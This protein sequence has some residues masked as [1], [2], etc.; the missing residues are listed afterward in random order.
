MSGLAAARKHPDQGYLRIETSLYGHKSDVQP[1]AVLLTPISAGYDGRRSSIASSSWSHPSTVTSIRSSQ[2]PATPPPHGLPMDMPFVCSDSFEDGPRGHEIEAAKKSMLSDPGT[3][4]NSPAAHGHFDVQDYWAYAPVPTQT[5]A[6][7]IPFV[8]MDSMMPASGDF[9][10]ALGVSLVHPPTDV[11]SHDVEQER[12]YPRQWSPQNYE[13]DVYENVTSQSYTVE[14][15]VSS[16]TLSDWSTTIKSWSPSD[17][18]V[19]SCIVPTDMNIDNQNPSY[20]MPIRDNRDT[21]SS[22]CSRLYVRT[23]GSFL[24]IQDQDDQGTCEQP[25]LR[26]SHDRSQRRRSMKRDSKRERKSETRSRRKLRDELP[27]AYVSMGDGFIPLHGKPRGKQRSKCTF[28]SPAGKRCDAQF[29][30][31]E[32]LKRHEH[33]HT[34]EKPFVCVLTAAELGESKPCSRPFSRR[35]NLRDHYKTHVKIAKA[36][37]N[38]RCTFKVLRDALVN[39]ETKEEADKTIAMLSTWWKAETTGKHSKGDLHIRSRL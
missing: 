3:F 29:E 27:E 7:Q 8:G 2:E 36:G 38:G 35:D 1:Q 24:S 11:L 16:Q 22:P 14:S 32:H 17:Y 12:P 9:S 34:G 4:L 26:K 33:T 30:R 18:Q 5:Q 20:D 19:E 39:R 6:I 15:D 21:S 28:I 13:Y 25:P 23:G 31:P 37:R 10:T